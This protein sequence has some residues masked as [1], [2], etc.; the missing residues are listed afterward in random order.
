M[1]PVVPVVPAVPVLVF[2]VPVAVFVLLL[3]LVF[4]VLL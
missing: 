1:L 4:P 2:D 3:L